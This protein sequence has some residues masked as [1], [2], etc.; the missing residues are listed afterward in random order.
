MI[1][2]L[3][4]VL[5]ALPY[6]AILPQFNE[7]A[8][9]GNAGTFG[10]LM[11]APGIGAVVATLVIASMREN[12]RYRMLLLASLFALGLSLITLA[13]SSQLVVVLVMLVLVGGTQMVYMTASQTVVQLAIPD[14]YRGR[15]MGIYMLNQ[16]MLPLGAM[17]AGSLADLYSA[18][19]ALVIMGALVSLM[20]VVFYFRAGSLRQLE[21]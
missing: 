2:A 5:I 6:I 11:S 14:E 10:L 8:L 20:A 17:F 12:V 21:G 9:H 4:P 19:T 16:G 18:S 7:E 3:V 1:L 13:L 15:V